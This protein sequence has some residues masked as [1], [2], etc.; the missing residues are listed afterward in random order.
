MSV[1]VFDGE[2]V[3]AEPAASGPL[4][5][6]F[7][8]VNVLRWE[9]IEA[10]LAHLH[11]IARFFMQLE[12]SIRIDS[13]AEPAPARL[14]ANVSLVVQDLISWEERP[15]EAA[16]N[17]PLVLVAN[18]LVL[19]KVDERLL[20]AAEPARLR[21]AVSTVRRRILASDPDQAHWAVVIRQVVGIRL[22]V[23]VNQV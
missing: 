6:G 14:L 9:A 18:Q 1:D 17:W 3:S 22:D 15:T 12:L 21:P 16:S 13:L 7:M 19:V 8:S 5:D 2:L 11:F 10:S 23:D 4:T 20:H